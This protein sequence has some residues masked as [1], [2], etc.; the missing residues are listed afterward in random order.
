MSS[1]DI[2]HC[3]MT[4]MAAS[5]ASDAWLRPEFCLTKPVVEAP[6]IAT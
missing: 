2:P 6:A 5:A 1:R 3:R 4:A